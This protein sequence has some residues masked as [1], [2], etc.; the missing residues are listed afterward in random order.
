MDEMDITDVQNACS[1][2]PIPQE[3]VN[4]IWKKKKTDPDFW[5]R[6]RAYKG[7]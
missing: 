1:M 7:R 6:Y 5:E 3:I 4:K 2:A